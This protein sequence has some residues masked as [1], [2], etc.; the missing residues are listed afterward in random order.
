MSNIT[1]LTLIELC[2][3]IRNKEL[4]STEITKAYIDRSIKS[5]KLN[6]YITDD[7][8]NALQKAKEYDNKPDFKKKLPGIPIAV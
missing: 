1:D 7:F 2:N 6:T 3:K 8:E 5:K 4:S